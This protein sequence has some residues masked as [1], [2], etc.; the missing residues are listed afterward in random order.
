MKELKSLL[1]KDKRICN[2]SGKLLKNKITELTLKH[3]QP[4][5]D[6]LLSDKK[7][8]E[9]FFIEK[10]SKEQNILIFDKDKFIKFVNN[11]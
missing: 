9:H 10:K 1:Q 11:K 6:L 5:I 3:D 7:A 2:P 4:L 8:K